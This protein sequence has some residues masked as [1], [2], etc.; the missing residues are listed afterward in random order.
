MQNVRKRISFL[1]FFY[2]IIIRMP[3]KNF[4]NDHYCDGLETMNNIELTYE[5]N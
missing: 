2:N 4:K 5:I 1:N 3:E